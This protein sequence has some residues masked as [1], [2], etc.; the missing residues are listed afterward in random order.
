MYLIFSLFFRF[1]RAV[2]YRQFTQLVHGYLGRSRRI[3]T[4]ACS[5]NTIRSKFKED[6]QCEFTGYYADD[7]VYD[8]EN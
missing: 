2:S 6:E 8:D 4:P 5:L 7:D 3:S 1:F